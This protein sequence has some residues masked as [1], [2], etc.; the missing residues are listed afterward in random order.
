VESIVLEKTH[1]MFNAIYHV[2][3]ASLQHGYTDNLLNII[4][5]EPDAMASTNGWVMHAV[6]RDCTAIPAG[7]YRIITHKKALIV[8][9]STDKGFP[10]WR[11]LL[12]SLQ[13]HET[14]IASLLLYVVIFGL[15]KHNVCLNYHLISEPFFNEMLGVKCFYGASDRPVIFHGQFQGDTA[16]LLCMPVEQPPLTEGTELFVE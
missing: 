13:D 15:A 9:E 11:S 10:P 7:T 3:L 6:Y 1:P 8:L 2:A 5:I 16:F 4:T 12:M 14:Y